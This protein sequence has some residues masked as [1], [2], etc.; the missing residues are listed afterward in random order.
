MFSLRLL[1]VVH[2]DYW[3]RMVVPLNAPIVTLTGPNG[4][5]KTTFIDACRTLLS[6][7]CST[8]RDYKRYVRRTKAGSAWLRAVV[9]NPVRPR[10]AR[11]FFPIQN[12]EVTVACKIRR[13]SGD[14][15][16]K[17]VILPGEVS[18]EDI[19]KGDTAWIGVREY[20]ERM[21]AAGLTPAMRKVLALDQGATDKLSEYSSRE[22]L[23][24]V[25]DTYG[26]Q[27]VLDEYHRSKKEYEEAAREL[28]ETER[29][30]NIQ[31]AA[32]LRLEQEMLAYKEWRERHDRC[33]RWETL[34]LPLLETH[35]AFTEWLTSNKDRRISRGK[36]RAT[37]ERVESSERD[38]ARA[39]EALNRLNA[40]LDS[41]RE[42]RTAADTRFADLR[43]SLGGLQR[44]DK[45]RTQL[46]QIAAGAA[47]ADVVATTQELARVRRDAAHVEI[48]QERLRT[49]EQSLRTQ[50]QMLES[51]KRPS[52]PEADAFRQV[53]QTAGIEHVML[54]DALDVT[55]PRWQPAIEGVLGALRAMVVLAK[56]NDQR[57]AFQLGQ[58]HHYRFLVAPHAAPARPGT[59]GRLLSKVRASSPLPSW[60]LRLLDE[61][62][63]VESV[64]EGVA[65]NRRIA[66]ATWVTPDGYYRE[67]RGGRFAGERQAKFLLGEAGRR[68]ALI[69]VRQ[70]LQEVQRS[71]SLNGVTLANHAAR[72]T[73]LESLIL[74]VDAARQL[75]AR[76]DEFRRATEE[77]EQRKKEVQEQARVVAAA[78][79]AERTL[80][81]LRSNARVTLTQV[82]GRLNTER[83]EATRAEAEFKAKVETSRANRALLKSRLKPMPARWRDHAWREE[84]LAKEEYLDK[85]SDVLKE[86][87][88]E[89]REYVDNRS[90]ALNEAA[91][92]LHQ[93]QQEEVNRLDRLLNERYDMR[94]R[95]LS[96]VD[97]QRA[98]YINV[99]KGSASAYQRHVRSLAELAGIGVETTPLAIENADAAIAQA[100]L[101]ISFRF[102]E[103]AEADLLAGDSSGGQKVMKSMILLI[104]LLMEEE[105]PAGVVF[106]DEPFAHL[107]IFNIDR[108]ASFLQ[109]TR[110]QYILT[111]PITH[112][113]NIYVPTAITL[114]AQKVR[115][116]QRHAPPIA[117]AVRRD[118]LRRELV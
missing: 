3:E 82:E 69:T 49:E 94:E 42:V 48:E 47:E 11:A 72:I 68:Q 17:Y 64:D 101:E 91:E 89:E 95:T 83:G 108:V 57:V 54:A 115:P 4:A 87:I 10:R 74:G 85:S 2:W 65:L 62:H 111:T 45:E 88:R 109:R 56:P 13:A 110:A 26:D 37:R 105:R 116:G 15:E 97:Q 38:F 39:T 43:E 114:V 51:G 6:I 30:L 33:L 118:D 84:L 25:F 9:S 34:I 81:E 20:Q 27:A 8:D 14:W 86:R 36:L 78:M 12:D 18:I 103:K 98:R 67:H 35:E 79:Q 24:L 60:L 32:A 53:L 50:Q 73:V 92:F 19:E 100:G 106:I 76:A 112:N 99:L 28:E 61:I 46:E 117:I 70:T 23:R 66:D 40:E 107:D 52:W 16:R 77:L 113:S 96:L 58:T 5:G 29:Q 90:S 104:A 71:I 102:D 1:E 63:C 55:D 21:Q 7:E 93:K 41:Q 22:L 59:M 80:E 75:A 44:I 31:K